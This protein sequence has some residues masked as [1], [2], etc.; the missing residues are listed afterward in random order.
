[1][2]IF[3]LNL[4]SFAEFVFGMAKFYQ[5]RKFIAILRFVKCLDKN[6]SKNFLVI[7]PDFVIK[8]FNYFISY[9]I[10]LI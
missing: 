9:L 3:V 2:T 8:L 6:F 1:M 4:I 5:I 10:F 7:N